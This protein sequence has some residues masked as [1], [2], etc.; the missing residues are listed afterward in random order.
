[1][2]I[3][4]DIA[5]HPLAEI[6]IGGY[7]MPQMSSLATS[8]TDR[9]RNWNDTVIINGNLSVHFVHQR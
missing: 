2:F 1:M 7:G 8:A 6:R 3:A 5:S 9:N 4:V